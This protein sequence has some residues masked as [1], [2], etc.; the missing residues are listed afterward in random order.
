MGSN[1]RWR[2][3]GRRLK[4]ANFKGLPNRTT[5]C[6]GNKVPQQI[7]GPSFTIPF[8]SSL[9][10]TWNT[11]WL[12]Y[13]N[14]QR[15]G[16]NC[17][18]WNYRQSIHPTRSGSCHFRVQIFK[19]TRQSAFITCMQIIE[20]PPTHIAMKLRITLVIICKQYSESLTCL[21]AGDLSYLFKNLR[22]LLRLIL[23]LLWLACC[24]RSN[25]RK[26]MWE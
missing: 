18:W 1:I 23:L 17:K 10:S 11:L 24:L 15:N 2:R 19:W 13:G 8:F 9:P 6:N 22:L 5:T 4:A 3:K 21:R 16:T 26:N 25:N 14:Y 20:F 12:D 7:L